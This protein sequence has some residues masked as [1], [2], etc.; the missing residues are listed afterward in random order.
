MYGP[1][2]FGFYPYV[3]VL[4]TSNKNI[5]YIHTYKPPA[6]VVYFHFLT[7]IT[8]LFPTLV[9][10]L[11]PESLYPGYEK[12]QQTAFSIG[13][14]LRGC[15]PCVI[16][17][18]PSK[19]RHPTTHIQ[20]FLFLLCYIILSTSPSNIIYHFLGS[21]AALGG[22]IFLYSNVNLIKAGIFTPSIP[23]CDHP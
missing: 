3:H 22:V 15:T 14:Y 12:Q 8:L 20:P 23:L 9:G 10:I 11:V 21:Y 19:C 7:L 5:K 13:C 16:S 2:Q 17:L 1:T 4:F 6:T 18:C